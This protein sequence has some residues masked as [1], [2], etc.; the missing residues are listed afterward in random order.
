MGEALLCP[1]EVALGLSRPLAQEWEGLGLARLLTA[2]QEYVP[3]WNCQ[4]LIGPC[5]PPC[6]GR[7]G[8]HRISTQSQHGHTCS[9]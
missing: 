8:Q 2:C 3:L 1:K 4:A 5:L 9:C 6:Q 7:L